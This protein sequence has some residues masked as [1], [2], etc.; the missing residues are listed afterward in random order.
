MVRALNLREI[1]GLF[2]DSREVFLPLYAAGIEGRTDAEA[3]GPFLISAPEVVARIIAMASNEPASASVVEQNMPA[4]VQLIALSEI[5]RATVPDQK[6][7]SLLLSEVTVLL[8][9][10]SEKGE[11]AA[12]LKAPSP[13]ILQPQ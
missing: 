10:L 11:L 3:L 4:T 8:Q 12:A 5:W 9:K 2:I 6:K 1:I 7:A 13:M